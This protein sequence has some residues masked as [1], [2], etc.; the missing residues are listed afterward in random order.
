MSASD[1]TWSAWLEAENHV[2]LLLSLYTRIQYI[3]YII[4][5]LYKLDMKLEFYV[6]KE[7]AHL[8]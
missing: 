2:S 5:Y 8:L 4:V 1:P 6:Y 7:V 3:I